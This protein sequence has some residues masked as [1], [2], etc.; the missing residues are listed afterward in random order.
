MSSSTSLQAATPWRSMLT[1]SAA[2]AAIMTMALQGG[3]FLAFLTKMPTYLSTVLKFDIKQVRRC[4]R[5]RRI[6]HWVEVDITGPTHLF[7]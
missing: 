7:W 6:F 5:R 3:V 1:S 2:W 4:G